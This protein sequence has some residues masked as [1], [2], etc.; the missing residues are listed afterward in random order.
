MVSGTSNPTRTLARRDRVV[1]R[2]IA[3][4]TL[5]VP[6][7]GDV[8]DMHHIFALN[9]VAAHVWN[10]IDGVTPEHEIIASVHEKFAV[11]AQRTEQ[12]VASFITQ[13]LEAGLIQVVCA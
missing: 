1:A 4:E 7:R 2:E 9:P 10:R 12:D 13:L 11:D 6:I 3:G 5:L 8:D